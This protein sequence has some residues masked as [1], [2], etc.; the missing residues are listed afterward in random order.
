LQQEQQQQQ[1]QQQQ[2]Q[3]QSNGLSHLVIPS[4]Y[5]VPAPDSPSPFTHSPT[6]D[7]RDDGGMMLDLNGERF[8][9][10]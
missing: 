3:Q 10:A 9:T 2:K 7:G 8:V 5:A 1:L 4:A 6:S